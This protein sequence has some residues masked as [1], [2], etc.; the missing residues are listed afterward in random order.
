MKTRVSKLDAARRQIH[1]AIRMIFSNDDPVST[2]TLIGAAS[3]IISNLVENG[4]SGKSWDQFA[5]Q[6]NNLAP[7][8][9]FRIMREAQNFFKHAKDDPD[10]EYEL[11]SL[12]TESIAFFTTL[13]LGEL[14]CSLTNRE[15]VFQLW[16]LGKL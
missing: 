11:D 10:L 5:Q 15:S 1:T 16:Y 4:H 7:S 6:A 14:G 3:S 12:D 13:N 8:D 2:H 9:Y